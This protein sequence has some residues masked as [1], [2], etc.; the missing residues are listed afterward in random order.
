MDR[1]ATAVGLVEARIGHSFADRALLERALTHASV[2][3]G[4]RTV[5]N[6]ETLEFLG[7]RVLG[8]L[9]AETLL[10]AHPEW[11]EG[12]LNRRHVTLVNG[13]AC[14]DVARGLGLGEALRLAGS[15][16]SQGGR[17]NDR[18]LGDAME[19]LIAA[20]YLDGGL[21][22]ARQVFQRA[23][24]ETIHAAG[25]GQDIEAKTALQ[26]WAMARGL[27]FPQYAVVGREGPAHAPNFTVEVTVQGHGAVSATGSNLRAA[28][29]AA[30][31][32]LLGR[33]EP[34]A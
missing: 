15:A 6:N 32:L 8:L 7:D 34:T 22:A 18:I 17:D 28:E 3:Q 5:A 23:W 30:A 9:A 20:V 31:G 13:H 33:L 29:K 27:P 25:P 2:G 24:R 12:D 10:R 1:R 14:A 21:E 4:A 16:T 19:A 11:R 26:E